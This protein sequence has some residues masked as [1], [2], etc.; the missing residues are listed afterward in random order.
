MN[1]F[2]RSLREL[3]KEVKKDRKVTRF[4]SIRCSTNQPYKR[5]S[6]I[7][8]STHSIQFAVDDDVD[9]FLEGIFLE[10]LRKKRRL[11]NLAIQYIDSLNS[12]GLITYE[13]SDYLFLGSASREAEIAGIKGALVVLF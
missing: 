9:S 7:A 12:K 8:D 3:T 10:I 11:S 4:V 13:F 5:K 2:I 1:P 6:R